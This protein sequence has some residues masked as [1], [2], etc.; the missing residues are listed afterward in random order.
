MD[1]YVC[2][3]HFLD[4][5]VI[6]YIED[7]STEGTCDYC[8]YRYQDGNVIELEKIAKFIY[9]GISFLYGDANDEMVMYDSSEGGWIGASVYNTMDLLLDEGYF[10]FGNQSLIYDIEKLSTNDSWSRIDPY[11]MTINQELALDWK[12]FSNVVKHQNRYSFFIHNEN[13]DSEKPISQI[14]HEIAKGV[15]KLSLIKNLAI[16]TEIYRCRQH[17]VSEIVSEFIHLTSPPIKFANFAN[18]MSPAG[19]SMFYGAFDKDTALLEVAEKN[20]LNEKPLITIGTFS[21]K[22]TLRIINFTNLPEIPSIFDRINRDNYYLILF[23]HSFIEDLSKDIK[24]DNKT[25][26]EYVPTQIMTEYF[27]HVLYKYTGD[28]IDGIIYN[29]SKNNKG[30]ACVLF[31]DTNT[32]REYL[33]LESKNTLKC[34]VA[35]TVYS[36]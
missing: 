4:D 1:K 36:V 31:L 20:Q 5:K 28:V 18:R 3:G 24:R 23:F 22:K 21:V 17:N 29:S 6:E 34:P 32:S 14:L 2:T 7:N 16:G 13:I 26:I 35:N 25:H 33:E 11:N 10:H 9:E 30:K 27:R 12:Q 19:I 15:E 8:D